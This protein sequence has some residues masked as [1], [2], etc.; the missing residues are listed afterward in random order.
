[1]GLSIIYKYNEH[2]LVFLAVGDFFFLRGKSICWSR[3]SIA[4][5]HVCY[6]RVHQPTVKQYASD[7]IIQNMLS[8]ALTSLLL[9]I[10]PRSPLSCFSPPLFLFI[11]MPG[12]QACSF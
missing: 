6:T 10:T 4:S 5:G 9:R 1:M 11:A 3:R 2:L 8:G 12:E 7:Q